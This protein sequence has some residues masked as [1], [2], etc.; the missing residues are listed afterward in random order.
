M[1]DW[2]VVRLRVVVRGLSPLIV[3]TVTVP[4][5][6]TLAGLHAAL[7]VLFDWSGE[8]LHEFTIRSISYSSDWIVDGVDT[9]TV[10]IGSLGLRTG[11]R[12]SWSYDFT[13]G[14]QVDLRVETTTV[15]TTP[16]V[17]VRC[18][19]GRRAGPPEWCDGLNGFHAWEHR[20]SVSGFLDAVVEVRDGVD[21]DAEPVDV[22]DAIE[23]LRAVA[24][25]MLRDR[26]NKTVVNRALAAL[27]VSPC[28]SSSRSG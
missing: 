3:R 23:H 15:D 24:R 9:R 1:D 13:A 8:H 6:A 4:D 12:F 26:F 5:V 10:T 21:V 11:E 17:T 16:A 7:L 25:W 19:S 22:G 28:V 18:V 2:G 14:W 20:H 27:E